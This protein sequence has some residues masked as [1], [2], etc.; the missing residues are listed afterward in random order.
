MSGTLSN[1]SKPG[2]RLMY[3][4]ENQISNSIDQLLQLLG[5]KCLAKEFASA[6]K[7]FTT[8]GVSVFLKKEKNLN[9]FDRAT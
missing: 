9:K 7:G 2:D 4:I 1:I 6:I 8:A 3:Y 5:Q